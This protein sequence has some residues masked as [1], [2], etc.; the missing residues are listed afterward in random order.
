MIRLP[1]MGQGMQDTA[2]EMALDLTPLLDVL[3]MVLIFF[4]L[5]ANSMHLALELELPREQADVARSVE[6]EA[7]IH[8]E[9]HAA[10][11]RWRVDEVAFVDWA[12]AV[13]H[14]RALRDEAPGSTLII[15][16]ERDAPIEALLRV[17]AFVERD[18]IHNVHILFDA[19]TQASAPPTKE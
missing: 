7:A 11:P 18:D 9:I 12:P 6:D 2:A 16:G 17:L 15:A 1:A 19:S 14:L 5:T 10:G 13:D 4:L 3:F 8:L